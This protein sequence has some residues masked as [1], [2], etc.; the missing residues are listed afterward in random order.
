MR[1][2]EELTN[3]IFRETTRHSWYRRG[4]IKEKAHRSSF[5]SIYSPRTSHTTNQNC[6]DFYWHSRLKLSARCLKTTFSIFKVY[7]ICQVPAET[8]ELGTYSQTEFQWTSSG[9][10]DT[11]TAKA[12]YKERIWCLKLGILQIPAITLLYGSTGIN[13]SLAGQ[14]RRAKD[15]PRKKNLLTRYLRCKNLRLRKDVYSRWKEDNAKRN[16]NM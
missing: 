12:W 10:Q 8:S 15:L 4:T 14:V 5:R 16:V 1:K 7:V 3:I 11:E 2:R 13:P 9:F 6:K